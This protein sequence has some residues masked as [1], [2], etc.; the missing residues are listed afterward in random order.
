MTKASS[1]KGKKGSGTETA[2]SAALSDVYRRLQSVERYF[3]DARD[4][5][6]KY[7]RR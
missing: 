1:A 6:D 4:M 5:S 7:L 2:Y 3:K